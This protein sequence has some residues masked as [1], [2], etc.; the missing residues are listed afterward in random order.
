VL[1]VSFS[2]LVLLLTG[3]IFLLP[4]R[5]STAMQCN[6]DR[7]KR[8]YSMI[9]VLL[10]KDGKQGNYK[11]FVQLP[12]LYSTLF[13]EG[14]WGDPKNSWRKNYLGWFLSFSSFGCIII[15]TSVCFF[16]LYLWCVV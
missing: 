1:S 9:G 3:V 15:R 16:S 14:D 2:F 7:E 6:A 10:G 5:S 13:L 4:S 12:F 11:A 8:P